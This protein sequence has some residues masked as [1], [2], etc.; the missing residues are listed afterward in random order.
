MELPSKLRE[1]TRQKTSAEQEK[2]FHEDLDRR[3]AE[4]EA[5]RVRKQA[6][7]QAAVPAIP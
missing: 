6:I 2:R 1:A 3:W 7:S 4:L 5:E